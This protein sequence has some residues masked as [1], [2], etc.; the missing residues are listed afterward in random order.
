MELP[1]LD[2]IL[3]IF[4]HFIERNEPI[5]DQFTLWGLYGD[6]R[7]KSVPMTHK[8]CYS[9]AELRM[10]TQN[11]GLTCE[12]TKPQTHFPIRDMRAECTKAI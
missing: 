6:P 10:I 2:S 3:R 8:W 9:K 1:C 12:F 11:A 4:N 7:Y 5:K